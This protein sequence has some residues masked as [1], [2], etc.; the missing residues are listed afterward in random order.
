MVS[1][2]EAYEQFLQKQMRGAR[3]NRLERLEKIGEGEKKLLKLIWNIFKSFDGF[4]LEYE[5]IDF[6]GVRIYLDVFYEPLGI[7]FECDGFVVHAELITRDR[8]TFERLRIRS[9]AM[10]RYIYVPFSYD[11][12]D[13]KAEACSKSIFELLGRLGASTTEPFAELSLTEKA[14]LRYV[15]ELN[16]PFRMKDVMQC[17]KKSRG[18]HQRYIAKLIAKGLITPVGANKQSYHFYELSDAARERLK[19]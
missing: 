11:E 2:E 5:L 17:V 4:H 7:V 3:G 6:N 13:K 15:R 9:M 10:H 14:L 1:F 8:F 18:A 16:R 19:Q 12:L